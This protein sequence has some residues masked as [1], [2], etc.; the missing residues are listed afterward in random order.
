VS[1]ALDRE[2]V[3]HL[4]HVEQGGH[5]RG[6]VL[7]GGRGWRDE[8]VVV[9]HQLGISGAT[10]SPERDRRRGRRDVDLADTGDAAA[11]SATPTTFAPA[12]IR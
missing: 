9:T 8:R 7:A 1:G 11:C 5:A 10:F 4:H 12:T 2:H 3:G 6:D